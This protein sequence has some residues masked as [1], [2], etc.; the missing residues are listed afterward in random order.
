MAD[1]TELFCKRTLTGWISFAGILDACGRL[2][3]RD[4]CDEPGSADDGP[5]GGGRLTPL[6]TDA[7]LAELLRLLVLTARVA[8]NCFP[9]WRSGQTLR[10]ETGA[11]AAGDQGKSWWMPGEDGT[12]RA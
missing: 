1:A 4:R 3:K 9:A 2:V 11:L 5:H 12:L 8:Q 6:S 10:H 7:L